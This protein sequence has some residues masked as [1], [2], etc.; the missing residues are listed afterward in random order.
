VIVSDPTLNGADPVAIRLRQ[1]KNNSF[2]IR[3]QEPNYKDDTHTSE[4]VSYLVMEAGDWS[5]ADGTRISAGVFESNRLSPQGFD[6]VN[7][8]GFDSTPA[9]LS[10]VQSFNGGD[11]VVTR[12]KGQ[13]AG[14]FQLAMQEEEALNNG[15]HANETLGW[16][17]IESGV[18]DDGDILL[19]G[20][21]TNR[22]YDNSRARIKF[23]EEFKTTPSIIAKLD[24][25]YGADVANLRLDD[26]GR[27]GFGVGVYEEQSLDS[28]LT[29][30]SESVSFL[31]LDCKSGVLTG[32]SV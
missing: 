10:Q 24:S 2:Q 22:S 3:L 9:V 27:T 14:G 7:L 28:E 29:H 30:T 15:K 8:T 21:R 18:V 4:S 13:S 1:V 12:T 23:E 17:A 6:S 31:A 20:G 16:L 32:M 19:Q 5:L 11:W 25:F 26:I